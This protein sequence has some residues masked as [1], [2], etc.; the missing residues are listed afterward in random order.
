MQKFD[1]TSPITAVLDIPAGR[2]RF[3]ASDRSDT[4]VEVLPADASKGRDVQAAAETVVEFGD[5]VLRIAAPA[6][7]HQLLGN[8]GYVA[9]TVQ[10]PAGSSVEAKTADA[11]FEG[12][13]RLGDVTFEGAQGKVELDETAGARLT[14][15]AGDVSVGRLSGP[16]RISTQKGAIHVTEAVTG[17]VTL[18][19]EHGPI[20]V[21][22]ARGVSASLDAGTGY[23]RIHNSLENTGGAAAGLNIH[24]TTSYGDITARSL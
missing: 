3:I 9:V 23:G 11:A 4:T 7:K 8:S 16:A 14:L 5:G 21:G 24:A 10:L 20:T 22:V 13:G 17:T 12:V 1:T 2:V 19:T 6:A 15:L 18:S